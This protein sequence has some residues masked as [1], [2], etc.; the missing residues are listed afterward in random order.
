MRRL[1]FAF[2]LAIAGMLLLPASVTAATTTSY[3]YHLEVPNVS[4]DSHGGRVAVIGGGT[5]TENPKS[6]TGGGTFTHKFA[7]GGSISGTWT[8]DELLEF[9]LYGCGV[10]LGNPIDSHA[11]GG[12]LKMRV[13]L[14]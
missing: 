11:C 5:F 8:A 1:A 3:Q 2:V 9:Q 6:V 14:T 10:V 4:E 13:T 7:G 12:A